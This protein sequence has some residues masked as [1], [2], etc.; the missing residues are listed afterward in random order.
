MY[1]NKFVYSS[2]TD[3]IYG[4]VFYSI[5]FLSM[6]IDIWMVLF[7]V[8]DSACFVCYDSIIYID[9]DFTINAC[10]TLMTHCMNLEFGV[11]SSV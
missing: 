9:P 10:R 11:V 2:A 7:I 5:A 6:D 1:R 4:F 8:F 3:R